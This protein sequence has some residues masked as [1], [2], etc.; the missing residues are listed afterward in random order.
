MAM[1]AAAM[2]ITSTFAEFDLAITL[3]IHQLY[4][5]AGGFFTPF[6]EFISFLGHDGIPLIILSAVL[7][8]FKKTRRFGTAMLLSLAVGALITN[9]VVKVLVARPRPYA[10]ESSVYYQLWQLVGMNTES[11]KSFPSG[12]TTAAVAF[13]TAIYLVGNRKI[14]WTAYFFALAMCVSRIYL[15]VHFPS[16]VLGGIVVGLIGGIIGTLIAMKLPRKFYKGYGFEVFFSPQK[17]KLDNSNDLVPEY[18][19]T[20]NIGRIK[21]APSGLFY[22]DLGKTYFVPYDYIDKAFIRVSECP[23]NEFANNEVYFRLILVNGVKEFANLI[24]N[25][26]EVA[27]RALYELLKKSP[28][29]ENPTF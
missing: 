10:D 23:E 21:C 20:E 18:I 5:L 29:T 12:H 11:D 22:R 25:K 7:I 14:S 8:I 16:D 27:D 15:V 17:K 1:N 9:C 13:S 6:F 28:N 19:G 2:W 26:E 24:F 3:F 4:T